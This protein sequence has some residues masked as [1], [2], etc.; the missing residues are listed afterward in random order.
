MGGRRAVQEPGDGLWVRGI[1]AQESMLSQE[2]EVAGLDI[3]VRRVRD[4]RDLVGVA[5]DRSADAVLVGEFGQHRCEGRITGL[6]PGQE[7]CERILLGGCHGGE[8]IEAGE[9]EALLVFRELDVGDR[10]A[11]LAATDRQLDPEMAVDDMPRRPVHEDLRHPTDLRQRTCEGLL[12]VLRVEAPVGR[13]RQELLRRFV[14]VADD[15]VA[16]GG[17]HATYHART[18]SIDSGRVFESPWGHQFP[19]LGNVF[20]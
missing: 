15:P 4:R 1:A 9:H 11:G 16:P 7:C 18:S 8:W 13:V 6:E 3:D 2:P 19:G 10:H 14:A 17:G 5:L 12:L 20:L